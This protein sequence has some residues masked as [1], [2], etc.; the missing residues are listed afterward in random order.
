M[1]NQY[2]RGHIIYILVVVYTLIILCIYNFEVIVLILN[3]YNIIVS[4]SII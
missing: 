1:D 4:K 3:L 2:S